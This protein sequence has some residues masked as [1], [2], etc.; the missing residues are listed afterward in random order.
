MIGGELDLLPDEVE[1]RDQGCEFFPSCLN[2]PLPKCVEDEPR[3]QQRLRMAA[4]KR[5]MEDLRRM[6]K[7]VKEIAGL[8]GVSR[9]TVQR[10][11]RNTKSRHHV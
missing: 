4:R 11:L 5:R 10:A 8:F 7:S 2:C 1:W 3:G 6:G 9:R